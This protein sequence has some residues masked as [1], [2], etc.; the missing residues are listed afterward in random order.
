MERIRGYIDSAT[1]ASSKKRIAIVLFL[2][3]V[4]LGLWIGYYGG[5]ETQPVTVEL[6]EATGTST[7]SP[8]GVPAPTP[9]ATPTPTPTATPGESGPSE[10]GGVGASDEDSTA[11]PGED[12]AESTTSPGTNDDWTTKSIS[13]DGQAYISVRKDG[14][15]SRFGELMP[16]DSGNVTLTVTNEGSNAGTFHVDTEV[17]DFENGRTE[18]ERDVD[19]SGGDPGEGEGE[20]SS[21]LLVR[22]S[23]VDSTGDRVYLTDGGG[24]DYVPI[25]DLDD[26]QVEGGTVPAGGNGTARF[27]WK[28]PRETGNEIQSDSVRFDVDFVL[29]SQ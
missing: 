27:E 14:M 22:W 13:R 2:L 16:G 23:F 11:D 29:V 26:S 3:I 18:P 4:V 7:P 9:T 10:K 5:E 15:E 8:T 19:D 6:A 1:E 17:T 12:T 28:V 20:L 21:N 25:R 24:D